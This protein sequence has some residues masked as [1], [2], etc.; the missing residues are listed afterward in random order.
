LDPGTLSSNEDGSDIAVLERLLSWIPG[1][2]AVLKGVD[3]RLERPDYR[4][5]TSSQMDERTGKVEEPGIQ[6]VKSSAQCRVETRFKRT[7]L[8]SSPYA[9]KDF[10]WGTFGLN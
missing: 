10:G 9:M 2:D 4:H 5:A 8:F 7:A 1:L 6:V 3:V